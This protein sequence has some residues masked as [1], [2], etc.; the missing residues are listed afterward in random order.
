MSIESEISRIHGNV[1]NTIDAIEAAGVDVPD[2]ANSDNLPSLAQALA[3][4]KQD[5][6]TGAEG[7]VVGFDSQGNAVAQEA[8]SGLPSG[9]TPGQL[10]SKTAS[11]VEWVNKPVMYVHVTE[12][13][14][15]YS[16][17]KTFEEIQAAYN[18][19]YAIFAITP[20]I[21]AG[22]GS[23]IVPFF[24]LNQAAAQ[25][26][27]FSPNYAICYT[28]MIYS[29]ASG[30]LVLCAISSIDADDIK[31]TPGQTGLKA[32]NVQDAIEEVVATSTTITLTSAGWTGDSAPF[33][34]QVSCSIVAADTPVVSVDVDTPGTDADADNE[35]INA[36][37]LVSQRNPAQGAG[38]LTF[39]ATEKPTVN[40]PVKVGVS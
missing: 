30:G 14:G 27:A 7:Q 29:A 8:P 4:T 24:G 34:Q 13:E 40:I 37:A 20:D 25:F 10:L 35:A 1:Q 6:L 28:T 26:Y 23:V 33:S 31:F 39:Y 18:A 17:D 3:N 21:Y 32:T 12:S 36:W 38:T 9:G 15:T 5:K 19:G 11:G 22:T 16:A 2:G